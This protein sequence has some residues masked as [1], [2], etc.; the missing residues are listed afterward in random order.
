MLRQQVLS[1]I[2][3]AICAK[4][5]THTLRVAIDGIDNAGK[6]TLAD[7]LVPLIEQRGRSVIRA[8]VD[9]FHRPRQDRYRHGSD[10]PEGYYADAFDYVAL[11]SVLLQP[12][13]PDGNRRYKRAVFDFRT[14]TPII[15]PEEEAADGAVLLFDGI[16]LQRPEIAAFWDYRM[17]VDVPMAIALQR[18]L[19]RD[20][21]LF[22]SAEAI[23]A[24]YHQRYFPAQ[25]LYFQDA[26]P[27]QTADVIIENSDPLHPS[28]RFR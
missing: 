25:Q 13:G 14:D 21:P 12:L 22:G 18:A 24:R 7:E 23:A 20:L 2:A 3:N 26:Q 8:S 27:Q 28:V 10:A 11:C 19:L 4:N 15:V 16:F 6:T 9:S 1:L 17:F 5:L